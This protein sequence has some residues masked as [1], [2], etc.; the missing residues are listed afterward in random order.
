MEAERSCKKP[1]PVRCEYKSRR[2][3]AH[4]VAIHYDNGRS[5]NL[6]LPLEA[7]ERSL[8]SQRAYVRRMVFGQHHMDRKPKEE[9]EALYEMIENAIADA[10][11]EHSDSS[12]PSD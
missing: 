8:E 3:Y 7:R 10:G 2:S 11:K 9:V 4:I 5:G 6:E 1:A 12:Q